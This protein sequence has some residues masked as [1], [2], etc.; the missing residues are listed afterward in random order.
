MVGNEIINVVFDYKICIKLHYNIF[1]ST[2]YLI[3]RGYHILL[4][5]MLTMIV[6]DINK[7]IS[8]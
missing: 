6:D 4:Y 3:N 5:H 7:D 8:N 2:W 1:L